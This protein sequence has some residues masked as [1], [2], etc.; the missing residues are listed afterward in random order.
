[1]EKAM[2]RAQMRDDHINTGNLLIPKYSI[3]NV[4]ET[5]I[6]SKAKCLGV[7]LGETDLEVAKSIKGIKMLEEKRILTILQKNM[8]ENLNKEDGLS[9]LVMSKVSN[10]CE[11]LINDE[12]IPLDL[13]DQLEHL[14]PVV[15]EKRTRKKKTYD[16]N[17]IRKSTRR[18]IKK[19]F[20]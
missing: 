8:D 7:S 9:T 6:I 20:S 13:D 3:V 19:K 4:P 10:L 14:K 18:I 16:T 1:M 2:K 5:D 12:G 15:K 11:D 17:N